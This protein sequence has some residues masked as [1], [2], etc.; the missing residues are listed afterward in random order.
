MR[1]KNDSRSGDSGAGAPKRRRRWRRHRDS[2]GTAA[3]LRP[4]EAHVDVQG[5]L[6]ADW[7]VPAEVVVRPD[8]FRPAHRVAGIALAEL[9]RT[10][11]AL[12]GIRQ[13]LEAFPA[14][15]PAVRAALAWL[16]A[17]GF[18]IAAPDRAGPIGTPDRT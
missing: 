10:A 14:P 16:V 15:E 17:E 18:L 3:S 1:R 13:T 4:P 11:C 6:E 2:R 9:F 8:R 5:V 7:I 12:G